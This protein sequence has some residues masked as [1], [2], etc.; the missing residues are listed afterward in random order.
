[1]NDRRRHALAVAALVLFPLVWLWPCVFGGRT[2]VP[3]DLAEFPPA[4]LSLSAEELAGVREGKNRDVTEVPVWFLPE[5]QFAHDELRAGRWPTWNP[6]A[7]GGT[8]LHAHGLIGLCYPPNW[9]ALFADDPGSRLVFLAWI[10]L[11]IAGVLTFGFLRE[12]GIGIGAAWFGAAVFELSAPM[13]TN[14]FFWMRLTAFVWLPGVLWSVLRLANANPLRPG[15][16]AAL[17]GSFAM[18][19]LAGFPP[20]ATTTSVIGGLFA[21]WLVIAHARERSMRDG[22][23]LAARL[24]CGFV[25]GALL[26][27]PQL[28]PSLQFFPQSARDPDPP[29]TAIAGQA[30]ETY[31]LLGYLA[32][33]LISHPSSSVE[34]PYHQSPLAVLLNRRTDADGKA[35]E[36]DYN[37]TEYAV[38]V[39]T[40]GLLLAIA[41]AIAGR[42]RHRA[43]AIAAFALL[44]G[45]ALFLPGVRLLFVLP[46]IKN[47]WPMRWLAPATLLVAWF[48]ALGVQRLA[49]PGRRVP[50]ALAAAAFVLAAALAKGLAMPAAAYAKD[51]AGLV[52]SIAARF[53]CSAQDVVNFVQDGAP[54]GTDRF[55]L[56]FARAAEHGLR[57][58][59][60][61]AASGALLLAIAF[62]KNAALRSWLVRAGLL[63]TIVQL[64][65]HGASIVRGCERHH[66][67]D[68]AVHTFLRERAAAAAPDGGVTI[69]R[70]SLVPILPVQLPPGELVAPGLRD[71]NFYTHY[72]ARSHQPLLAMLGPV[73]GA[74]GSERL[75]GKGYLVQSLPD[76]ALDHPLLDLLGVRYVLATER[77]PHGGTVVGP[78][79]GDRFFV[80]ERPNA[81]PRAFTVPRL[82]VLPDDGAVLTALADRS[83][84][85]RSAAL[86]VAADAPTD[87]AAAPDGVPARAVRFTTDLPTV[88]ELDVAAGAAPWLVL[89]D[90][91][92]PGWSASVDG[93]P[94]AIVRANHALRAVR[95]PEEHCT[96]RFEYRA[97]GLATGFVL[98]GIAALVLLVFTARH[99]HRAA[100][101]PAV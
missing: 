40:L 90:T 68:T 54:P 42:G 76:A 27:M 92:L 10:S 93:S 97:P 94:A 79:L 3:Y 34:L 31:G 29:F 4:S 52:Q 32:P 1:M 11:A 50:I 46:V 81:L 87:A 15:P 38:F 78:T 58:A 84:A 82:R 66:P 91:F 30:F 71:L 59:V 86:V 13:A 25:L 9:L 20:F 60:W 95:L 101:A 24:G 17:A 47:V 36:P 61:L 12:L 26:G 19:W 23:R 18:A 8:A 98:A 69:V 64:A 43:F 21:G 72:D 45:L 88:V 35:Q 100:A 2:F 57:A 83:L 65:V 33:D 22:A 6:H 55:A 37:Y 67:T 62:A 85:P 73:L 70:G 77:L 74:D 63:A 51:A 14:A 80:H 5:M 28:L 96:V 7:R 89:T 48:A 39:G 41:G 56:A 49:E 53:R 44:A 99:R 75:A 16:L